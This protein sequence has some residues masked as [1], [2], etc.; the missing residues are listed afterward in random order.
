[1]KPLLFYF[2]AL[3]KTVGKYI[4]VPEPGGVQ[5]QASIP[6]ARQWQ[7]EEAI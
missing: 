7:R 1:M 3:A 2:T 5:I 4:V 6:L